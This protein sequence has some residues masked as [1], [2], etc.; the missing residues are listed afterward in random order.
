M[1]NWTIVNRTEYE[2]QRY[3]FLTKTEENGVPKLAPYDDGVGYITIGIGFNLEEAAVRDEVFRTFG[4]IRNNPALS[5]VAPA[6]G[7]LSAQQVEN[8]YINQLIATIG[9]ASTPTDLAKLNSIMTARAADTRLAALG[10]RRSTFAFTGEPEIRATFDR[11]MTN[12]YE[13]KVDSW[14]SGIPDSRERTALISLAWNQKDG[15]PLLGKKLKAAIQADDRAEA[16]YEIRYNSNSVKQAQ[17]IR[18]GIAKRRYFE[19][20]TFGLYDNGANTQTTMTDVAAKGIFRM[21][22]RHQEAID[23]YDSQFGA[24]VALANSDYNT[25]IV[26][27]R[28]AWFQPARDYLIRNYV[29]DNALISVKPAID[30]DI[31]VGEDTTTA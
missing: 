30:G 16:W 19:A 11:L 8:D 25:T 10:T 22:T 26:D 13:P 14:L 28:T 6:P 1:I 15:S 27:D 3:I 5:T 21:Y 2:N 20:D 12:I 17:N 18:N 24:Q 7:Q 29:T 4:I 31:L 23:A 9:T